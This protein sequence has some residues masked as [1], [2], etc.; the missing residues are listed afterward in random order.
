MKVI[1]MYFHRPGVWETFQWA[2]WQT[3]GFLEVETQGEFFFVVVIIII[4]YVTRSCYAAKTG[5][6]L[7]EILLLQNPWCWD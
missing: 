2:L 3:E 1:Q 6:E 4:Y 5:L 7:M